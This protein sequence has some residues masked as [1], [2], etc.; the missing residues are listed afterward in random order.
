MLKIGHILKGWDFV[1]M[2]ETTKCAIIGNFYFHN[3]L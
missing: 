1:N 3:S 2:H